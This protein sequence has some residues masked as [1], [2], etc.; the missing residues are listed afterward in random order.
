MIYQQRVALGQ[1][2]FSRPFARG[3][4]ALLSLGAT[5]RQR[6]GS[7]TQP[8]QRHRHL[9]RVQPDAEHLAELGITFRNGV[10]LASNLNLLKQQTAS[11]GSLT[12]LDQADLN[13]SLSYAFPLPRALSRARKL[14]RSSFSV[15]VS[16]ATQ[17]LTPRRQRRSARSSPIPGARSIAA[18]SIPISSP[19]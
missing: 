18:A 15:V 4:F 13:G 17:C 3:P 1:V 16:K 19:R 10:A 11:N 9:H 6:Q 14:A 8:V 12:L 7:T 5:M 2:R